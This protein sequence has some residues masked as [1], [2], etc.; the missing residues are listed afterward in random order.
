M[1]VSTLIACC[2]RLGDW[3]RARD[4]WQWMVDQGLE[5][6]TICYS[7]LLSARPPPQPCPLPYGSSA[8]SPGLAAQQE[9]G[10]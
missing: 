5:P 1:T 10:T 2:E 8:P 7:E 6:D 4:V 3:Q 9:L